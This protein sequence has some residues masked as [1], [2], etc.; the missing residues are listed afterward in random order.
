[1]RRHNNC[2]RATLW[3]YLIKLWLCFQEGFASL[4]DYLCYV[5]A[6]RGTVSG[7][8]NSRVKKVVFPDTAVRETGAYH[9]LYFS[10]NSGSVLGMSEAFE[11]C[12]RD[13]G[14][15][16]QF[17]S[18]DRYWRWLCQLLVISHIYMVLNYYKYCAKVIVCHG[19]WSQVEDIYI[20]VILFSK[21]LIFCSYT[22]VLL[23]CTLIRNSFFLVNYLIS[24]ILC[25]SFACGFPISIF[26]LCISSLPCLQIPSLCL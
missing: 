12:R 21:S 14:H 7:N 18:R 25:L 19:C 8:G 26:A 24:C 4:D 10:Y 16:T 17:V 15:V 6:A 11:V 22:A 5:Y 3:Y 1:M 9:L 23:L 2:E 20:Y 13:N